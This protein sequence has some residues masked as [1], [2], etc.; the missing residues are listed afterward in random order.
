MYPALVIVL[1]DSLCQETRV[2]TTTNTNFKNQQKICNIIISINNSLLDSLKFIVLL[3]K[4]TS[5]FY[6][7]TVV[8]RYCKLIAAFSV[9]LNFFFFFW[10]QYLCVLHLF[11]PSVSG[12]AISIHW[13]EIKVRDQGKILFSGLRIHNFSFRS[14]EE[15]SVHSTTRSMQDGWLIQDRLQVRKFLT[16]MP[17]FIQM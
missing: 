8:W 10:S 15:Y 1:T 12:H 7:S 2:G 17:L 11:L 4:T 16:T 6:H 5:L 14:Y 3:L 13:T 9:I